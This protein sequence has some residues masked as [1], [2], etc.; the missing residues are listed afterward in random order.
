MTAPADQPPPRDEPLPAD[1]D[2]SLLCVAIAA[3]LND[4]IRTQV[5]DD[6]YGDVR[7]TH[8]YVFQHLL[9]GPLP[10]GELA[11]RLGVTQQA[12]SKVTAELERLGYVQRITDPGDQRFRRVELTDRAWGAIEA[13]RRARRRLDDRL[14]EQLGER[15]WSSLIRTLQVVA[16]HTG[17]RDSLQRRTLR[18]AR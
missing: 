4:E 11:A 15:R 17:A 12:A 7:E 1:R 16:D 3:T 13:A 2:L 5:A 9:D 10:V 14:R 8:G 18:Q 6:G